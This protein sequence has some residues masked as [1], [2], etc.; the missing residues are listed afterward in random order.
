M[1]IKCVIIKDIVELVGVFKVIVSLV[2][3]GCGKEL[4]V[5]QEMCECVLVIVCEQYYQLSIYVC[6]LCD[7]CSYIIGLVVLEI[8]NY[9]FV[10]FFYEFEMFCWE[11]GVQL[12]IFCIDENSG[13]ESVVVNN[14]IVCQVDGLIVVFCMYSDVDYQ[15]FS[16]QLLVVLFDCFFSDSVL[17]LVMID[18][19]ILMVELIFCIVFQYVDEFWFFGGQ[20]WLLL[21][22]DWLV[23]FIQG[24]V[25]VGI[26]L[27]FEWV[28]NGNYY[29]SFGYEMFV[30]FCVW[31]G[32]LLKVF[33]IVV[34]GLF[35]GVLCYMSQYYLLDFNIYF[36]SF[37][38]Y[39]LYDLFFLCIDIVQ[40]DNCQLVW[41]CYDLFSQ[42][43]DGQVLEL[44]QCYLFVILQICYF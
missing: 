7:N 26:M 30:V 4:C 44:F 5:V 15:K 39:Y 38:D 21:L 9:G 25:Q 37:D 1:K 14:M 18:L 28:I 22:C 42:L 27:C 10:V 23:G 6:L 34:C 36:V 16:E 32:C 35:E 43:I 33:F 41:Y 29:F 3:N 20:L 19:V 17:L 40:Q 31:L 8:I 11:V 2:F 13:Q 12:F 24:L